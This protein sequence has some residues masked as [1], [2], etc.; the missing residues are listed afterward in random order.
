MNQFKERRDEWYD[1]FYGNPQK[2]EQSLNC[3]YNQIR[4]M[5]KDD[6]TYKTYREAVRFSKES[7]TDGTGINMPVF[8]LLTRSFIRAQIMAVRRLTDPENDDIRKRIISIPSL[9]Q[10]IKENEKLITRENY[11]CCD[12]TPYAGPDK[13]TTTE[14]TL[15]ARKQCFFDKMSKTDHE[16]RSKDDKIDHSVIIFFKK[17]PST[18]VNIRA[19]S[20]KFLAHAAHPDNWEKALDRESKGIFTSLDECYPWIIKAASFIGEGVLSGASVGKIPVPQFNYEKDLDKP[21]VTSDQIQKIRQ[22]RLARV[23][24]IEQWRNDYWPE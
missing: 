20:N 24:E 10:E 13:I 19:V 1:L 23:D 7:T 21:A 17:I 5:L 9:I 16:K 6:V 3:I 18:I 4:D 8:N 15:W 14:H 2:P 11:I 22:F 12:G